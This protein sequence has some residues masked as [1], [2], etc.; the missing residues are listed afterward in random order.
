M[1]TLQDQLRHFIHSNF[2]L[3]P[4]AARFGNEDSLIDLGIMDSTGYLELIDHLEQHYRLQ[5]ADHEMTPENLESLDRIAAFLMR[6]GV[7]PKH[8]ACATD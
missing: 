2:L 4:Q 3:S 5:I 8:A 7:A 1:P 6:K